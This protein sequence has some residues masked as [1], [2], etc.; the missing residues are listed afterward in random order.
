MENIHMYLHAY[1]PPPTPPLP[2]TPE[3]WWLRTFQQVVNGMRCSIPSAP[4]EQSGPLGV[5][6]ESPS[7]PCP[8]SSTGNVWVERPPPA[9]S[10]WLDGGPWGESPHLVETPRLDHA[11][12]VAGTVREEVNWEG[13]WWGGAGVGPLPGF[14]G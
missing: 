11:Q 6:V 3:S 8:A 9:C 4:G 10:V 2:P 1:I 5:G 7:P 14:G 12:H 13:H